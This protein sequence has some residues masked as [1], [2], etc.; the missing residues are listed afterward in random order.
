M[1]VTLRN[2]TSLHWHELEIQSTFLV[3]QSKIRVLQCA[4]LLSLLDAQYK[5]TAKGFWQKR[6]LTRW[7]HGWRRACPN[8]GQP[9]HFRPG[10]I[11]GMASRVH[12]A[13]GAHMQHGGAADSVHEGKHQ[14][15][16]RISGGGWSDPRQPRQA[17]R[18]R[19]PN[20]SV[21][22]ERRPD[23]L[24]AERL[25]LPSSSCS[26]DKSSQIVVMAYKVAAFIDKIFK[27]DSQAFSF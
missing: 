21:E 23:M 7:F 22:Q 14:T 18:R 13:A 5:A 15:G 19:V 9:Q 3:T 10:P 8:L 27:A 12:D 11:V 4:R 17:D 16:Q 2:Y 25:P 24:D 6:L 1:M 20:L 26:S